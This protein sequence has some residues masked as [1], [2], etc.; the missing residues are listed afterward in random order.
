MG[1]IYEYSL[2]PEANMEMFKNVCD[3]IEKEIPACKK[4][5]QGVDVD[6][7]V[8]QSYTLGSKAIYVINDVEDMD[9]VYVRSEMALDYLFG[10]PVWTSEKE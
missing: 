10:K 3:K 1:L 7:T 6:G 8:I 9:E 4:D 5:W 2:F